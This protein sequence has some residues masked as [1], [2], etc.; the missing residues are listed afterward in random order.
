MME[1]IT[2]SF[3]S[4]ETAAHALQQFVP[5]HGLAVSVSNNHEL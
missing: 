3:H 1:R 5:M 4:P 2:G